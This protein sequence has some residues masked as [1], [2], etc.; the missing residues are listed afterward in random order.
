MIILFFVKVEFL[1]ISL[2]DLILQF[3]MMMHEFIKQLCFVEVN[4]LIDIEL[5]K[6]IPQLNLL[7]LLIFK[8]SLLT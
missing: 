5:I 3:I 8:A 1:F 6:V 4:F 2:Y 7:S